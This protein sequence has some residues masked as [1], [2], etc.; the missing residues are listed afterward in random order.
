MNTKMIGTF[1]ALAATFTGAALATTAGSAAE[2]SKLQSSD[3]AN[4]YEMRLDRCPYY[5][6]PVVCHGGSNGSTAQ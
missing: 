1:V 4:I 3:N 2:R 6:S 5:P